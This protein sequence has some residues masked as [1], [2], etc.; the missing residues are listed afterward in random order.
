[1]LLSLPFEILKQILQRQTLDARETDLILVIDTWHEKS[2]RKGIHEDIL[3]K[4]VKELAQL[5]KIHLVDPELM[6][7]IVQPKGWISTNILWD[8]LKEHMEYQNNPFREPD[9]RFEKRT[10]GPKLQRLSKFTV[11]I[12]GL[13]DAGK[14][15]VKMFMKKSMKIIG[16]EYPGKFS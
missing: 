5:L 11:A 9:P 13:E 14:T 7:K 15:T 3:N 4:Q 6:F 10:P 2:I 12:L 1:M 8:S 16:Y